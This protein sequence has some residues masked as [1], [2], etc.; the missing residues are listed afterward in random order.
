M[1]KRK[2]DK[3]ARV[4]RFSANRPNKEGGLPKAQPFEMIIK[5]KQRKNNQKTK[6]KREMKSRK[7][8]KMKRNKE[9]R[10]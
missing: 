7:E 8:K 1:K 10:K 9:K 4:P 2:N 3:K 5:K 6:K